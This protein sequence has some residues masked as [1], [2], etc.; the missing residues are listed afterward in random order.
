MQIALFNP[1]LVG[2]VFYNSNGQN[3]DLQGLETSLVYRP[4]GGL[5]FQAAAS[6]NQ[7]KQVNSPSLIDNNPASNNYGHPITTNCDSTGNNCVAVSNVYGP[8]GSPTA[9]SPPLQFSIRARYDFSLSDSLLAFAQVGA[10]HVGHSY[11]Q[12]GANPP[13][14]TGDPITTGR[15]RFEDPAY[16]T[17]DAS[18]GISKDQ[19]M[20]SV[21]GENLGDSHAAVFTSTDQFIVA[22]TPLR[23]RVIGVSVEYKF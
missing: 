4:I 7:S 13:L 14:T 21:F 5:T 15:L 23:P 3:F 10:S 18:F 2:N 1:G 22:Q 8:P 17:F 11:T 6:W 20:V 16:T 19:W 9:D 12:A